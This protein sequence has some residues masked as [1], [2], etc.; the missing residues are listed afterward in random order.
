MKEPLKLPNSVCKRF[1]FFPF[2]MCWKAHMSEQGI[3]F[4]AYRC[5][6]VFLCMHSIK[7]ETDFFCDRCGFQHQF[8]NVYPPS[9]MCH[10]FK[11]FV[12]NISCLLYWIHQVKIPI[13]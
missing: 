10:C 13:P 9:S 7:K 12:K 2:Q 1:R 6:C 11:S 8:R 4:V 3:R 5:V